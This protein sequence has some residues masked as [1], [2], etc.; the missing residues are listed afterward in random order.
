MLLLS[1]HTVVIA[2]PGQLFIPAAVVQKLRHLA[3]RTQRL[4]HNYPGDSPLL[5]SFVTCDVE[6]G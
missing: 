1:K 5:A 3:Q 4:E 2:Q 6:R